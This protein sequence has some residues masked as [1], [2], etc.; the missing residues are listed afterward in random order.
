MDSQALKV[1]VLPVGQSSGPEEQSYPDTIRRKVGCPYS[2]TSDL[3]LFV[4]LQADGEEFLKVVNEVNA[5]SAAK[6]EELDG[7]LMKEFAYNAEGDICPIQAFIGGICAQE[8]MKVQDF[9]GLFV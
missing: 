8:V 1:D 7:D 9:F 6:V 5:S 2:Y 4:L 3:S